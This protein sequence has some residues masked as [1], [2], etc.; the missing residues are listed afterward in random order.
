MFELFIHTRRIMLDPEIYRREQPSM[1]TTPLTVA[2]LGLLDYS[3]AGGKIDR[4]VMH[5]NEGL[6]GGQR[7]RCESAYKSLAEGVQEMGVWMRA[8][9]YDV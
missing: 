1:R 8:A 2:E 3:I 9:G 6:P 5:L 7:L 4:G